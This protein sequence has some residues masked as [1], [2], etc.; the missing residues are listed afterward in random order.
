MRAGAPVK[1]FADL[2][3]VPSFCPENAAREPRVH[4]MMRVFREYVTK[5]WEADTQTTVPEGSWIEWDA[6]REVRFSS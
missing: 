2:E 1:F 5:Q 4:V 3:F 6:S